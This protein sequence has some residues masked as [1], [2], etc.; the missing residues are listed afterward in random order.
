MAARDDLPPAL[1]PPAP[2]GPAGQAPVQVPGHVPGPIP[3]PIPG[4][5]PAAHN[6]GDGQNPPGEIQQEIKKAFEDSSLV[7]M[8]EN[9]QI[10]R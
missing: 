7:D 5:I 9:K 6:E 2:V 10:T 3:D 4:Q 1:D 8:P